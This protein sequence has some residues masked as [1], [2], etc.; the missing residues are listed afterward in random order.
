MSNDFIQWATNNIFEFMMFW[1]MANAFGY[2]CIALV[3]A[4]LKKCLIEKQNYGHRNF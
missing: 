4:T 1:F 2:A 3:I